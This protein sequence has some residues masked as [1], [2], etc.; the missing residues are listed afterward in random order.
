[1]LF[2]HLGQTFH[3]ST[4]N[5]AKSKSSPSQVSKQTTLEL[6]TITMVR[7]YSG[8]EGICH[9]LGVRVVGLLSHILRATPASASEN[10]FGQNKHHSHSVVAES[11]I[12][13]KLSRNAAHQ[14]VPEVAATST[15]C[16][17]AEWCFDS[18]KWHQLSELLWQKHQ[19][20]VQKS[21]FREQVF[22]TLPTVT[23]HVLSFAFICYRSQE[24]VYLTAKTVS[25]YCNLF[26]Q[27]PP[28]FACCFDFSK[29]QVSHFLSL[30]YSISGFGLAIALV[31]CKNP[32]PWSQ[33][34]PSVSRHAMDPA[35]CTSVSVQ[36]EHGSQSG[37]QPFSCF[38]A[39]G[40]Q[41]TARSEHQLVARHPLALFCITVTKTPVSTTKVS[42]HGLRAWQ[43]CIQSNFS[44]KM[45]HQTY[46]Q[47][48][49]L[50]IRFQQK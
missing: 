20:H 29:L 43:R 7:A 12:N 10:S 39:N 9:H 37:T 3:M 25:L 4:K 45:L 27:L 6:T 44:P 23:P 24:N 1:M 15:P 40:T 13:F 33:S 2:G 34:L 32:T 48:E 47:T 49:A 19:G 50:P 30:R 18:V 16:N 36:F 41:W 17:S 11:H 46:I 35:W 14:L 8:G 31:F 38:L 42:A 22:E 5:A 21:Y 28:S 26:S